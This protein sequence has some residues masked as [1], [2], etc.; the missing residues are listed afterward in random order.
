[1]ASADPIIIARY[2]AFAKFKKE[3]NRPDRHPPSDWVPILQG[4][5]N[6]MAELIH[7]TIPGCDCENAFEFPGYVRLKMQSTE[8]LAPYFLAASIPVDD[9][10]HD[11][12]ALGMGVRIESNSVLCMSGSAV[13]SRL[14]HA[15]SDVDYCEY[16]V[17]LEGI[18][19]LI[20]GKL[21][22]ALPTFFVKGKVDEHPVHRNDVAKAGGVQF[23][24]KPVTAAAMMNYVAY[25]KLGYR[26]V[27]N[28]TLVPRAGDP[29]FYNE[30]WPF[31]EVVLGAERATP[32]GLVLPERLG[33]YLLWLND[34][35]N[36]HLAKK[37]VKA[38]KRALS[39]DRILGTDHSDEILAALNDKT[40]VASSI[41]QGLA[42][43]VTL[44]ESVH[45]LS[46][47]NLLR[48]ARAALDAIMT[49][50][51]GRDF[52]VAQQRCRDLVFKVGESFETYMSLAG[53]V[54]WD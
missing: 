1:M 54:L 42:E 31:Q 33:E 52:E 4:F 51:N 32:G 50:F 29:P 13:F 23:A 44:A 20:D 34:Q 16:T 46:C 28:L 37:P 27:S 26:P 9:L 39:L 24:G 43:V 6:A 25:M 12:V 36:E 21:L 2:P 18:G 3:Q 7:P 22:S 14:L 47:E 15:V 53:E 11:I 48:D 49:D 30:T 41:A 38:L 45:D 5:F 8:V 10:L 17:N 35:M 40:V 19:H